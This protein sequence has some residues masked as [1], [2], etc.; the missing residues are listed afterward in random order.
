MVLSPVCPSRALSL[1]CPS[2]APCLRVS[3]G[4]DLPPACHSRGSGN[5]VPVMR[6]VL[7]SLDPCFRR[8]DS[9]AGACRVLVLR[10]C[11]TLRLSFPRTLS[12]VCPSSATCLSSVLPVHPACVCPSGTTC[13]PPVIPAEAGIQFPG[14]QQVLR[15]LDPCFRRDDSVV[16]ARLPDARKPAQMHD[17]TGP[18][19]SPAA[20]LLA[21]SGRPPSH[22]RSGRACLRGVGG[23]R[24][25]PVSV[26][27]DA[28]GRYLLF[29]VTP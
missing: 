7:R 14:M 8:D 27:S 13:P 15:S 3:F 6:R 23:S 22:A 9:V 29:V 20:M 5:P 24:V 28:A 1:V 25:S 2:R 17:M 16:G 12:C 11:H 18:C 26:R 4:H 21:Q 19:L 10:L